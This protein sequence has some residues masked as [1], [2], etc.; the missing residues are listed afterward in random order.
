MLK[1]FLL[2]LAAVVGLFIAQSK[3]LVLFIR[4]IITHMFDIHRAFP[5]ALCAVLLTGCA[6]GQYGPPKVVK[7]NAVFNPGDLNPAQLEKGHSTISG[8]TCGRVRM[9][10]TMSGASIVPAANQ[11]IWLYPYTPLKKHILNN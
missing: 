11:K 9:S 8:M 5:A 3:E 10:G 1:H 4:R 6:M 7:P 2:I